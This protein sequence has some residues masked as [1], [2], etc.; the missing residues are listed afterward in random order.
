MSSSIPRAVWL[1]LF[2][3]AALAGCGG[4]SSNNSGGG[5]GTGGGSPT[6]VTYT[7]TGATPTVVATQIGAG[8]YTQA[9]LQ[10]NKL[11]LSVPS[12][13]TNYSVAVLCPPITVD[14]PPVN[15]EYV[16]QRSTL[17]GTSFTENC[18]V[19]TP[20][21][22][23]LATL[24]V[25]AAAIPGASEV[26]LWGSGGYPFVSAT[27]GP[28]SSSPLNFSG[29][30]VAGTYDVLVVV[31]DSTGLYPL[32]VRILR[33][34]TIP[35][36]LNGGNPV[37]FAAS[38]ETVKQ[39]ITYNNVPAGSSPY[40]APFVDFYTSGGQGITLEGGPST[41]P[42]TQY[43]ALPAAAPQSGDYY[44]FDTWTSSGAG[45]GTLGAVV[46]ASS[47]GPQTITFPSTPWTYSG[48]TA[49]A[50]PTFNFN[51]TGFSGM[52]SVMQIASIQWPLGVSQTDSKGTST[53]STTV[54][55]T[56]NYQNG[57]TTLSIPNLSG[58]TG[59]LAPAPSGT[60]VSWYAIVQQGWPS[61]TTP[62]NGT[63]KSVEN[64]GEYTE[65]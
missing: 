3:T 47:G 14:A 61:S 58:L 57:D 17:D 41:T 23:G 34:Q 39:T 24:Q 28:P 6:L 46:Y 42:A 50:L 53:N 2:V 43:P 12:G 27:G 29:Q 37:V 56:E 35:G 38:D 19:S 5:G 45:G 55:A 18:Y 13:T 48:P 25:N 33:S 52:L 62:P 51:Y 60:S 4:S 21:Q 64:I 10:S 9:S 49:A 44:T 36:A 7:F 15:Q 1:Y 22:T 26:I 32:A 8:A 59:F 20:P 30:M 65:P 16:L 54:S 40:D 11:T 63:V 31:Y